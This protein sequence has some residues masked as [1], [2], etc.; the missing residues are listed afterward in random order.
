MDIKVAESAG[1]CF[2]VK[3][4]VD[5]V[6]DE[7]DKG[8][9]IYTYGSI[10]HNET[11]VEELGKRG[12]RVIE[13]PEELNEMPKG[14]IVIRSHGVPKETLDKLASCGHNIIDAT[15]PFVKKIHTIASK[16]ADRHIIII[17]DGNHPEVIGII[18]WCASKSYT[19][20]EN[21]EDAQRLNIPRDTK[22]CIVAQ[23][24]FNYDRFQEL[25]EI[26]SKKRL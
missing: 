15:C 21:I 7:L 26:I 23:T 12:V 13:S 22:I 9:I 10:I 14:T 16:Y 6:Y 4:A 18:G 3:R 24:T 25:V 5:V 11:V 2:G 1:F 20:I 19:V 17:G 8:G